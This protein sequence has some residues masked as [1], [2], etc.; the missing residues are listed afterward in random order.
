MTPLHDRILIRPDESPDTSTGGIYLPDRARE[1]Q[2]KGTVVAVGEGRWAGDR[3]IA[4]DVAV[5]DR[6]L[7][8]SFGGTNLT[9]DGVEMIIMRE[10]D[11]VGVFQD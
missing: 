8:T 6:V 5:G 3:L 11:I 4:P 9:V 1:M 2:V 7:Y 10:A